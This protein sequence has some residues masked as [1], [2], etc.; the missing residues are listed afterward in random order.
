MCS[1][2]WVTDVLHRQARLL[3]ATPERMPF[4]VKLVHQT[5]LARR[6][7]KTPELKA[8]TCIAASACAG[9]GWHAS[10]EGVYSGQPDIYPRRKVCSVG[11]SLGMAP[12]FFLFEP[13]LAFLPNTHEHLTHRYKTGREFASLNRN[14]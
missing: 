14:S 11:A 5:C 6:N 10:V 8:E 9:P 4:F 7:P 3:L 13:G 12:V 1:I 2:R